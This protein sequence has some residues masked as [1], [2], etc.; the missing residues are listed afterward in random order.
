MNPVISALLQVVS[1]PLDG[2]LSRFFPSKEKAQEF[3]NELQKVLLD[4]QGD[5]IKA[6]L[7]A[8][9]A[10]ISVNLEEAKSSSLFVAGWRPFIGWT[11]GFSL[12]WQFVIQ[13]ILTYIFS[14]V[15]V[16]NHVTLSPLPVLDSTQLT[17]IVTAMLGLAGARTLE[18]FKGVD[19]STLSEP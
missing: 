1:G 19:R 4:Q 3:Q 11:G 9:Q 7:A 16:Y 2:L 5:I 14:L 6:T 10:Q 15:A 18:K 12:A 8:Q 13:P 17:A